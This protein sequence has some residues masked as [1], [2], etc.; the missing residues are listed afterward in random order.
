M[1]Q[2]DRKRNNRESN[3]KREKGVQDKLK[4]SEGV[5]K[6]DVII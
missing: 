6:M 4:A 2:K 1:K 3:A 5:L